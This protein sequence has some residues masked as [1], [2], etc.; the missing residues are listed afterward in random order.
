MSECP[1]VT[2]ELPIS[3]Y[4][5]T[6]HRVNVNQLTHDTNVPKCN[7]DHWSG[8][9]QCDDMGSKSLSPLS[10]EYYLSSQILTVKLIPLHVY[11]PDLFGINFP[12]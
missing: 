2:M 11:T 12:L 6:F 7:T 9:K 8:N 4:E 1:S 3:T 5:V 10:K